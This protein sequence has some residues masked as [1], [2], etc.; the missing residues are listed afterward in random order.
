MKTNKMAEI[1][2]ERRKAGDTLKRS[3]SVRASLRFFGSKLLSHKSSSENS[4]TK[5]KSLSNFTDFK[6]QRDIRR[7][8]SHDGS[9]LYGPNNDFIKEQ[10]RIAPK[11]VITEKDKA[12]KMKQKNKI[13]VTTP[14]ILIAPKAAQLLEIPIKENLEHL[15]LHCGEFLRY[16]NN[17]ANHRNANS[18][19]KD[20]MKFVYRR[21]TFHRK[22]RLSLAPPKRKNFRKIQTTE[23]PSRYTFLFQSSIITIFAILC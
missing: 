17:S 6:H 23:P 14:P 20:N 15:S 19:N 11:T 16:D 12:M 10:A 21:D 1:I 13:K 5:V 7:S 3:K 9:Y 18:V 8:T 4:I 22:A 2:A